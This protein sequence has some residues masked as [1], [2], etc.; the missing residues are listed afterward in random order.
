MEI[1]RAVRHSVN[2]I[3][4]IAGVSGSGKTFSALLMA[5]GLAGPGGKIGFI[6]TENGRGSMYAD[7]AGIIAAIPQGYDVIEL[8]APFTPARYIEAIDAFEKAG[9][10]V[11]AIDSA[12]HEWEGVGGCSDMA[13]ADKGRWNRAK[14]ENKK[15]VTRLLNSNMHIIVCLRAREK[16]KIIDKKDS[17]DGKEHIISLGILPVSEKNFPFEMMLSF[18]VD[19][20]THVATPIKLPEQFQKLFAT[21]KMLSK[22]DGDKIREWNEGATASDPNEKLRRRARAAADEGSAA[23]A[24]FVAAMTAP[25]KRAI[26]KEGHEDLLRIASAADV[27]MRAGIVEEIEAC[28]DEFTPAEFAARIGYPRVADI[29]PAELEVAL[30]RLKETA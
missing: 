18:L 3:S 6:D 7:A 29:P 24:A 8:A 23:Y 16:S 19:E 17:P 21:P 9:Y 25:E 13:E 27:E 14:R 1:K 15:F 11:L 10:R 30:A 28:R 5:G 26:G 2:L 20:K 22:S 12:S 4:S